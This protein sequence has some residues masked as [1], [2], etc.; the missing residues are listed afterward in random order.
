MESAEARLRALVEELEL[1][2]DLDAGRAHPRL[3][4]RAGK[5]LAAG[6]VRR[7]GDGRRGPGCRADLA[8]ARRERAGVEV[9]VRHAGALLRG[10]LD[11]CD[12]GEVLDPDPTGKLDLVGLFRAG[13]G[14]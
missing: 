10:F 2:L 1:D 12:D 4:S 13:D 9:D 7:G 3:R 8:P 11:Q 14:R 6:R 5:Q